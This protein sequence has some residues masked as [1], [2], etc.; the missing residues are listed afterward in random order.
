M[1]TSTSPS[2]CGGPA[3]CRLPWAGRR[4]WCSGDQRSE[5]SALHKGHT[6]RSFSSG[7]TMQ[8]NETE[9]RHEPRRRVE[10]SPPPQ[11]DDDTFVPSFLTAN[12]LQAWDPAKS[13]ERRVA[14][15]RRL[16]RDD[17]TVRRIIR[18]E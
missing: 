14:G 15:T 16:T 7:V 5:L 18:D 10:Q 6:L 11:Q 13:E 2:H 8:R 3:A 1:A 17:V 9:R 12:E 4:W